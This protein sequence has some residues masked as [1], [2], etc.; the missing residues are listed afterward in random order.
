MV[1]GGHPYPFT[2]GFVNENADSASDVGSFV[3]LTDGHAARNEQ[4]RRHLSDG[5]L[6]KVKYGLPSLKSVPLLT[7]QWTGRN[8]EGSCCR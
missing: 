2:D 8:I 4:L 7:E 5:F 3:Y 6:L 1:T